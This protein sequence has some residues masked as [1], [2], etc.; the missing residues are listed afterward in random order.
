MPDHLFEAHTR[1][2]LPKVQHLLLG[3]SDFG[4]EF[5]CGSML[6][7]CLADMNIDLCRLKISM[8]QKFFSIKGIFGLVVFDSAFP[9]C[10]CAKVELQC[11]FVRMGSSFCN[12]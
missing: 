3:P 11:L 6:K 2:Q 10:E 1:S 4:V 5:I 9:M 8:S 12:V 7:Q